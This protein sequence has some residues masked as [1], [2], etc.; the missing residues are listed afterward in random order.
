MEKTEIQ[1]ATEQIKYAQSIT[2]QA[3][4]LL[5]LEQ[6]KLEQAKLAKRTQFW[7]SITAIIVATSAITTAW[8]G[9][10]TWLVKK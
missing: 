4:E 1:F 5:K 7:T 8:I 9:F 10:I 3:T 6:A 2:A